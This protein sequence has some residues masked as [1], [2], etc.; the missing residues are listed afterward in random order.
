MAEAVN[1]LKMEKGKDKDTLKVNFYSTGR[2]LFC[3]GEHSSWARKSCL[4]SRKVYREKGATKPIFFLGTCESCFPLEVSWEIV[5]FFNI[6]LFHFILFHLLIY[7]YAISHIYHLLVWANSK[8]LHNSQWITFPTQTCQAIIIIVIVTITIL[9]S[10]I[11][12]ITTTTSTSSSSSIRSLL[13]KIY[14]LY[15]VYCNKKEDFDT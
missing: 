5:L 13:S 8:F 14:K 10:S 12:T 7:F 6:Y 3:G 9:S 15:R 11:S 4:S 2:Q 1:E